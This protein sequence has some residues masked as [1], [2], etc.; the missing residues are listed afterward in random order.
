MLRRPTFTVWIAV[1]ML[2]A[3]AAPAWPAHGQDDSRAAPVL[4]LMRFIPNIPENRR[5]TYYGDV[6]A[7]SEGWGVPLVRSVTVLKALPSETFNTWNNMTRQAL[8]GAYSLGIDSVL[9]DEMQPFYGFDVFSVD[10]YIAT[11]SPPDNVLVGIID[12]ESTTVPDKLGSSAIYTAS[13]IGDWTLYSAFGDHEQAFASEFRDEIPRAGWMG[14]LNRIAVQ[15][16]YLM[17][18]RATAVIE[19]S[20]MVADGTAPSLADDDAFVAAVMALD[21]PA[22]DGHGGLVGALLLDGLLFEEGDPIAALGPNL[23]PE[24]IEHLREQYGLDDI[25]RL[26]TYRALV[27]AIF[28]TPG[29]S[30]LVASMAFA[31]DTDAQAIAELI[32]RRIG[33][34]ELFTQRGR[35]LSDSWTVEEAIGTEVNGIPVGLV[36][37]RMDDPP[38]EPGADVP[39]GA[40]RLTWYDLVMR[41]DAFF[42][43]PLGLP[44][45]LAPVGDSISRQGT[46]GGD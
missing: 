14:A 36:I 6:V 27:L 29:T 12:L 18:A 10:R 3:L 24:Q 43:S 25:E 15:D 26:F 40:G 11:D 41:R 31:P 42:L 46:V 1:V 5:L 30:Y 4:D 20:L 2:L 38:L 13:T 34:Y 21:D 28:H 8:V 39:K 37:V 45:E 7:G 16:E 22:L 17:V 19:G 33:A 9:L 44:E 35:L 32:G 23:T